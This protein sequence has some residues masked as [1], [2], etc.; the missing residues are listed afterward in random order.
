MAFYKNPSAIRRSILAFVRHLLSKSLYRA[1]EL[2]LSPCCPPVITNA[3]AV[4]NGDSTFN[5]T[6]TLANAISL[7]GVGF[8]SL[9]LFTGFGPGW[10]VTAT[11]YDAGTNTITFSNVPNY[12]NDE[13]VPI[14]I[15]MF[16][17]TNTTETIGVTLYS[18]VF[19]L[20]FP[21]CP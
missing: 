7:A 13:T 6:V 5:V 14:A 17:P 9:V 21:I 10:F 1:F 11:G 8:D 15:E 4:C 12:F 19:S 2:L 20:Y 3:T 16:L 18:N